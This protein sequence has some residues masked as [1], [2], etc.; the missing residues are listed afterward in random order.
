MVAKL[1]ASFDRHSDVIALLADKLP[2][3][4][5]SEHHTMLFEA[6]IRT[7]LRKKALS[8]LKGFPESAMSDPHIRSLAVEL[9]QD[10]NDWNQLSHLSLL[11]LNAHPDRADAWIFR[12]VVLLRQKQLGDAREL[13]KKDIPLD[14]DG[15]L[16]SLA[17]LARLEIE[18]GIRD[19]GFQ[20]LYLIFRNALQSGDAGAIYLAQLL[21]VRQECMPATPEDVAAGSAIT[22]RAEDGTTRVVVIDPLI[23]A[24]VSEAQGFFSPGSDFAKENLGKRAKD[25]ISVVD[26]FG[27][28]HLYE[29]VGVDSAYR[30][31]AGR[32][33][34]M[35]HTAVAGTGPL[36]SISIP[37][38]ENGQLDMSSIVSMLKS[39]KEQIQ[40]AIS[41]YAE[42]PL[43]LGTI[44]KLIGTPAAVLAADWPHDFGH[45]LYVCSGSQDERT[46]T[47]Q[48]LEAWDGPVV[49]D[50][51]A[52]N[53]L[54][55]AGA[56]HSLAQFSEVYISSSAEGTLS[57]LI[58]NIEDDRTRGHAYEEDGRISI[59][60]YSKSY[61]DSQLGHLNLVRAC[62]DKYC[63]VVPA[64][65]VDEP[66]EHLAELGSLLDRDSFDALLLC[67]ER[68]ALLL[69]VDGRLREAAGAIASIPSAWPQLFCGL[70]V[71]RKRCASDAYHE[72]VFFSLAR[73]RTHVSVAAGDIL[74]AFTRQPAVRERHIA[75]MLRYLSD[76]SVEIGSAILVVIDVIKYLAIRG[77]SVAAVVATVQA[78]V[79]PFFKRQGIDVDGM[80]AAF[81]LSFH[82]FLDGVFSLKGS[83]PFEAADVAEEERKWRHAL[84]SAVRRARLAADSDSLDD[85][86]QLAA[87][88]G[89]CYATA[90]P[91]FRFSKA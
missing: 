87:R 53:E 4:Y 48:K 62:I 45:K 11:Q 8:M 61:R 24:V 27:R 14:V 63:K 38:D 16:R 84:V 19:R 82:T 5:T 86:A 88:V 12:A 46:G 49:V 47:Y 56:E 85:L 83:H 74:W 7:S 65:G 43:P 81:N 71:A 3:G 15:S 23:P 60:E 42:N 2:H 30:H 66:P 54:V 51:S 18:S 10:A 13:L 72:L 32:A 28:K 25:A 73:H 39:R 36:T 31:L 35:I 79:A 21:S 20:R 89:P 17:Q 77:G 37:Q 9:A 58:N 22:L 34:E 1:C 64:W 26:S 90:K 75:S 70:A 41:T 33:Q 59:V 40:Q 78:L 55:A 6:Y 52:V 80:E 50:L 69:T 91:S 67:L 76:A 57:G 68:K 29:I 44:A